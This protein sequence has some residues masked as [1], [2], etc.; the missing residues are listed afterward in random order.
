VTKIG[1]E[2]FGTTQFQHCPGTLCWSYITHRRIN[3][4]YTRADREYMVLE[5][6]C[7]IC[8]EPMAMDQNPLPA[9]FLTC[10]HS[11][12][13][14]CLLTWLATNRN[15]P[16]CRTVVTIDPLLN[17]THMKTLRDT[18]L[19]RIRDLR[20]QLQAIES[21]PVPSQMTA[22]LFLAALERSSG[23]NVPDHD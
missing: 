18:L 22:F 21:A 13:S 7:S 20:E 10:Q 12:C 11:V 3:S 8:Y 9:N 4:G 6:E 14:S 19:A 1:V 17:L 2:L 5:A 15:C 23:Q 16:V